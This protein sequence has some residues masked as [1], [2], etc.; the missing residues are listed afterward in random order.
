MTSRVFIPFL[1]GLVGAALGLFLGF[2]SGDHDGGSRQPL[3]DAR[4]LDLEERLARVERGG[5]GPSLRTRQP[6]QP[7][8]PGQ[9]DLSRLGERLHALEASL[10]APRASARVPREEDAA[11]RSP[12]DALLARARELNRQ[13]GKEHLSVPLWREVLKRKDVTRPI[14]IET[15]NRLGWDLRELKRH[16]DSAN[17]FS[18]LAELAGP[19]TT[20]GSRA[21]YDLAWSHW[22]QKDIEGAFHVIRDCAHARGSARV[23]RRAALFHAA[24]WGIK[25]GRFDEARELA[26]ELSAACKE[27]GEAADADFTKQA[28][29]MIERIDNR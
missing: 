25:L 10:G 18:E 12:T 26:V 11:D 17:A 4:L 19:D 16:E 29:S 2:E 23:H 8:Q 27:Y 24:D 7:G 9:L 28:R 5:A 22:Y 6:G 21:L 1:A 3:Q 13:H 15:L 14:H 20:P